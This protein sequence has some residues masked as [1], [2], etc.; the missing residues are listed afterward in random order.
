MAYSVQG[1]QRNTGRTHFPKGIIPW[2][3]GKTGIKKTTSS[4][5]KFDRR[6]IGHACSEE[7]KSILREFHKG[8]KWNLGK[9]F[10]EEHKKKISD[11]NK[12]SARTEWTYNQWMAVLPKIILTAIREAEYGNNPYNNHTWKKKR[13]SIYQRDK[14][15]CQECKKLCDENTGISCHHIDYNKD[16]N[17]SDNLITLCSSCHGKTTKKT[18]HWVQYYQDKMMLLTKKNDTSH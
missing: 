14:F 8:K 6:K 10:S 1:E 4:V 17:A 7:T 2:N 5:E 13:K 11:S 12:R 16:N 18:E 9:T 15:I 3:K